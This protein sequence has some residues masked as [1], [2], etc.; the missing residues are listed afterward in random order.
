M[1]SL[2]AARAAA[3]DLNRKLLLERARVS[4]ESR[5]AFP[6]GSISV[7][8]D[9]RVECGRPQKETGTGDAGLLVDTG[10]GGWRTC[11]RYESD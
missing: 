10:L 7:T 11:R 6:A 5:I 1:R 8:P 4:C 2:I 3:R 9:V